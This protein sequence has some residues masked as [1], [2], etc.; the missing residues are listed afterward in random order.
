MSINSAM[1]AGVSGL[2]ANSAA[3]AAISNNISNVNTTGFKRI[4]SDFTRMVDGAGGAVTSP[5]GGVTAAQ[6]QLVRNQGALTSTGVATDL[7]LEGQG[8]FVVKPT[9]LG[10]LA[11]TG[12]L[13]SRVGSFAADQE[14]N[15]VN[16]SG[17]YLQGWKVADDGSFKSS[18]GDLA[19][20]E[21]VSLNALTGVA[22]PSTTAAINGNLKASE[23]ANAA[24]ATYN[25]SAA[26]TNMA[27]GTV[28][29]DASW[30]FRIY[31]S[32]GGVK[33]FNVG[34]LK[35]QTANQWHAEI[36]AATAGTINSGAPL[37]NGQIAVG[38]LAFKPDGKLDTAATS[39]ALLAAINIGA[40][41]PAP[42][43]A[44]SVTWGAS[45]GIAAQSL[46]LQLGQTAGKE[47][48]ITQFD[49]AT[50]LTSAPS[51]GSLS[52]D[53][54]GV[55]IDKDGFV[56]ALFANGSSRKVYKLP[57]ATFINP[58]GLGAETGGA[59]RM[60]PNSGAFSLKEAGTGGAGL[61]RSAS[62]ESS[63]VDLALEFSS[64][65]ITQRAYSASSKIIT[66]A[67]EMLDELIRMKR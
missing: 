4:R 9:N 11:D 16:Q 29:P 6:R 12:A 30:S 48:G 46:Q 21:T 67:D 56:S 57:I 62:L 20:L 36:Y 44:G 34:L 47:G 13:F 33:T 31:D 51:D 38:T 37:T 55:S 15:L 40:S 52:G 45:T 32:L 23:T 39:P 41:G 35:S 53:I 58:D 17:H 19:L 61:V 7:G 14:G 27:S 28:T 42:A 18:S 24:A 5:S 8:F 65:I 26:A 22:T 63:T 60:T 54:A 10:N 49:S 2:A 1:L 64:M 3:M 50:S 66:T 43:P 25:A 59:Y